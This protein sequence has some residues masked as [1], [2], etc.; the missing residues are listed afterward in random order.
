MNCNVTRD[1]LRFQR[2]DSQR[3]SVLTDKSVK[4]RE[5]G[6]R[7]SLC[8]IHH[9]RQI[10]KASGNSLYITLASFLFFFVYISSLLMEGVINMLKLI[11]RYR[12]QL[13]QKYLTI[14]KGE[15]QMVRTVYHRAK[16]TIRLSHY[17]D[18]NTF[19]LPFCSQQKI[20]HMVED[21]PHCKE[22]YVYFKR[23]GTKLTIGHWTL[24]AVYSSPSRQRLA[25]C[26]APGPKA[27]LPATLP[28]SQT[29][30]NACFELNW[31]DYPQP[32]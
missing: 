21:I 17:L 9:G 11:L 4:E 28:L 13:V 15:V 18:L 32:L 22:H 30:T 20:L 7:K 19:Y 3:L 29:V 23:S 6:E 8:S 24:S 12:W 5:T 16:L 14:I 31:Q 27:R 10:V 1:P 26:R 25:R 2:R